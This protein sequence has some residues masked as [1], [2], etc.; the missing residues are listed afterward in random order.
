MVWRVRLYLY[1][2][3]EFQSFPP[4]YQ[5]AL[6][7]GVLLTIV[8]FD[9]YRIYRPWRGIRLWE[10]LRLVALAWGTVVLI[11]ILIAFLSKTGEN[12]SRVWIVGW[13]VSSFVLLMGFR[14]GVRLILRRLRSRGRNLRQIVIY[15]SGRLGQRIARR[16]KYAPWTG[17]EITAF[18]D[19]GKDRDAPQSV[20]NVP[21]LG[22][23]KELLAYL[24][25]N[26]VD[27]V[28]LALPLKEEDRMRSVLQAIQS[29]VPIAVRF[30]PDI[31]EFRLLNYSM[32]DIAGLPVLNLT[33]TPMLGIK[34]V[35]KAI[36]DRILS[37]LF[38]VL[39][40][41]VWGLIALLVMATS[42]GPILYRQRRVSW[43]GEEFEMLK[44]RTMPVDSEAETGPVWAQAKDSRPTPVGRLLRRSSLDEL[45]QLWNVLRGDMSIV[46]PRPERPVFI[47]EFRKEIP[48]YMQKHMVKAGMTGWAQV[49]GWRGDT[50]LQT[51]IEYDLYY[52]ENWSLW[53]DLKIIALTPFKG[54][55]SKHAY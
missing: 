11:L 16:L 40:S 4:R 7:L 36:E 55:I 10:E 43:N 1:P 13:G 50:D 20:E 2:K 26:D 6:L 22:G 32:T 41:P 19:D 37:T 39:F 14:M 30:V 5:I 3:T 42:R 35:V 38:L 24:P 48:D 31:F 52:I 17:L 46:G 33:D 27:Q 28:W 8:V 53:L 25:D 12:F 51:R 29:T 15:G 18:F 21:V 23:I 9:W 44:F 34:R 49:N 47:E 45:P 54:L